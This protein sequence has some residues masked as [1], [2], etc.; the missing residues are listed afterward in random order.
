[1]ASMVFSVASPTGV[2]WGGVGLLASKSTVDGSPCFFGTTTLALHRLLRHA[3][4]F[5][6]AGSLIAYRFTRA[7]DLGSNG[8]VRRMEHNSFWRVDDK[9]K[10]D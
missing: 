9:F 3:L 8:A 4:G 1:M 2:G 5:S 6:S 7:M 10:E